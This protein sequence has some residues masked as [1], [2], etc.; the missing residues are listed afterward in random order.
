[1]QS[2]ARCCQLTAGGTTRCPGFRERLLAELRP[3]VP[4]DYEVRRILRRRW[5]VA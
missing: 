2:P 5:K 1:M 4:D 3:L